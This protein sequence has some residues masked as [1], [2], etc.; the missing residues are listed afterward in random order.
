[1]ITHQRGRNY[2]AAVQLLEDLAAL[3]D[4]DGTPQAFAARCRTLRNQHLTKKALLRLLDA[5]D[6]GMATLP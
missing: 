5:A 6:L 3:A 1:M 2:P 4:R